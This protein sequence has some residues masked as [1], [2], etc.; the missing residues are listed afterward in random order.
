MRSASALLAVLVVLGFA[1]T[2]MAQQK[3]KKSSPPPN[4][5][6]APSDQQRWSDPSCN[7]FNT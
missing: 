1:S 7:L 6:T 4:Q 3:A 5:Y 2:A